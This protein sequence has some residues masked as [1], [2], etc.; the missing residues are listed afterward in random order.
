[1]TPAAI[2]LVAAFVL[3]FTT[4]NLILYSYGSM[5]ENQTGK[6]VEVRAQRP[7]CTLGNNTYPLGYRWNPSLPKFGTFPCLL[8]E[9]TVKLN[10]NCYEPVVVC[11]NIEHKCPQAPKTCRDGSS[12]R[13]LP[14]KCCKQCPEISVPD[15]K[16]RRVNSLSASTLLTNDANLYQLPAKPESYWLFRIVAR[17]YDERE[18]IS[19]VRYVTFCR[20]S[21]GDDAAIGSVS[22]TPKYNTQTDDTMTTTSLPNTSEQLQT[23]ASDSSLWRR[24][25]SSRGGARLPATYP[26]RPDTNRVYI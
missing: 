23:G 19:A 16:D 2:S 15:F 11:P 6:P 18:I 5:V 1:M 13:K 10:G 3:L 24:K 25:P 14:D 17:D 12:P 8:C 7:Y 22:E 20:R 9:C 21:S 26:R 4:L